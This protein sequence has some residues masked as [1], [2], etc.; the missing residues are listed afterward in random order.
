MSTRRRSRRGL[1]FVELMV[2]AVLGIVVMGVAWSF[3]LSTMRRGERADT[4]LEG[5]QTGLLL[6][7]RLEQDLR[8]V[9]EEGDHMPRTSLDAEGSTLEIHR[10]ASEHEGGDWGAPEVVPV[11][12]RFQVATGRVTRQ[13]GGGSPRP[14]P[15]TFEQVNF[16][17]SGTEPA[18]AADDDGALAEGP[19]LVYSLVATPRAVLERPPDQRRGSDRTVLVGGVCREQRA[20]REAYPSW[21]PVPYEASA[22]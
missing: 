4:K 3:L 14:F 2:S 6:A 13:V 9:F 16:R 19:A 15:G 11:R 22:E 5:V 18:D 8:A 20:R 17:F 1:T 10:Y 21:N 7:L 12:Y